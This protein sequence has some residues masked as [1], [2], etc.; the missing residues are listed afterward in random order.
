M[1]Y[2][3]NMRIALLT[4]IH[5]NL[6]A[7]EIV[8]QAVKKEKPDLILFGDDLAVNGPRPRETMEF[9]LSSGIRSIRGNMDDAVLQ[10]DDPVAQWARDQISPAGIAYL[11]RSPIDDRI[12]PPGGRSPENDL[13]FVHSTPLSNDEALILELSP[14]T[15]FI[16]LTPEEEANR[17]LAGAM[18]SRIVYGHIHYFSNGIIRGQR[19]GSIGS[20]GFPFDGD[21][22]AAFALAHWDGKDWQIEPRRIA[23]NHESVARDIETSGQPLPARYAGM[24]RLARWLPRE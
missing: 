5:A 21:P 7:L 24:I 20:V 4:D 16:G 15:S 9:I 23:Y 18:A 2:T 3:N 6:A 8:F 13:L 22:R 12:T 1:E 10:G 19:V 11:E 17:L 14:A